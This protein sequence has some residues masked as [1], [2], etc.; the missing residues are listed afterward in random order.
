MSERMENMIRLSAELAPAKEG[1]ARTAT[2]KWYT[3]R[4]LSHAAVGMVHIFSPY[5]W[6]LHT[7]EWNA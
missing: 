3:G 7:T 5:Q 6:T 1:K 2:L 4:A